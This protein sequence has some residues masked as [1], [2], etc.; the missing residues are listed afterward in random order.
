MKKV[1]IFSDGEKFNTGFGRE[2]NYILPYLKNWFDVKY[3]SFIENQSK[4]DFFNL[5]SDFQPDLIFFNQDIQIIDYFLKAIPTRK[6]PAISWTVVDSEK[7]PEVFYPTILNID[8]H[9]FQTVTSFNIVNKSLP[10]VTG[11][12]IYP[13]IVLKQ[14]ENIKPFLTKKQDTKIIFSVGKNIQRKNFVLLCEAL[15]I[16]NESE[17]V[18][19]LVCILHTSACEQQ[20]YDLEYLRKELDLKNLIFTSELLNKNFIS[21][22][23]LISLYKSSDLYVTPSG[24]EGVGLPLLE[25]MNFNLPIIGIDYLATS[26]ILGD[27]RGYLIKPSCFETMLGKQNVFIKNAVISPDIL[28]LKIVEVL[29]N[30]PIAQNDSRSDFLKLFDLEFVANQLGCFFDQTLE[31][32]EKKLPYNYHQPVSFFI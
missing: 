31:E 9:V 5:Y 7:L 17:C 26:E 13:P 20:G 10:V 32:Y 12:V 3:F 27:N 14:N 22:E 4:E 8:K 30:K 11:P 6:I 21:D 23:E 29:N 15:K 16:L 2:I 25:A 19:N 28:A 24:R 18:K 1:L